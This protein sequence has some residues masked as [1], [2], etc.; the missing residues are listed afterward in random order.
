[1]NIEKKNLDKARELLNELANLEDA[2]DVFKNYDSRVQAVYSSKH[3][4]NTK[5]YK[6]VRIK[7]PLQLVG[8][9]ESYIRHR[10]DEIHKEL[11]SL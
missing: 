4:K 8:A 6:E 2:L 7:M 11:K 3:N 1:M 10:I 5:I 9:M